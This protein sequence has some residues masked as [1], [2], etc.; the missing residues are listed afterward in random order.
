MMAE[1]EY[2]GGRDG[3]FIGAHTIAALQSLARSRDLDLATVIEAASR[4]ALVEI[5]ELRDRRSRLRPG[6]PGWGRRLHG[7]DAVS[8]MIFKRDPP[9]R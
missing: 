1:I 8:V 6:D 5:V 4:G 9:P 7:D 3:A 2:M